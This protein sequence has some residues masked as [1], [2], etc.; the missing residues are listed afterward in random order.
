MEADSTNAFKKLD[1]ACCGHDSVRDWNSS[2]SSS[3][4]FSLL[5]CLK[6]K[7]APSYFASGI[8]LRLDYQTRE[9]AEIEPR[10]TFAIGSHFFHELSVKWWNLLLLHNF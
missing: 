6:L 8:D 5:K 4:I 7:W 3:K 2:A 1:F 9:T 10:L